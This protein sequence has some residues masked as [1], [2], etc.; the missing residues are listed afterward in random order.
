MGRERGLNRTGG[1]DFLRVQS[2]VG[3]LRY[4]FGRGWELEYRSAYDFNHDGG[5][6]WDR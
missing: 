2:F 3:L 5:G 1:V 6:P 4:L